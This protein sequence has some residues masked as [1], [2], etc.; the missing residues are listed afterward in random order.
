MS[1][2]TASGLVVQLQLL[3]RDIELEAAR[4]L[5]E[6]GTSLRVVSVLMCA[7]GSGKTQGELAELACLDKST[8]VHTIDALERSGLATRKPSEK[9][10]RARV[11]DVTDEGRT[12]IAAAEPVLNELYETVLGRLPEAERRPFL[13]S[14]SK[15]VD[16][17]SPQPVVTAERPPRRRSAR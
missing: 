7:D 16:G 12:L 9:D 14:L 15:L 8:M 6:M 11:V 10:R 1:A 2:Q 4:R 3:S 17:R 13:R 5:E